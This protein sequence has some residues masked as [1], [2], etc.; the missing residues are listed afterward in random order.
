MNFDFQTNDSSSAEDKNAKTENG[1]DEK[2]PAAAID[3]G[4]LA[5][6]LCPYRASKEVRKLND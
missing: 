2:T 4:R 1:K 6:D 3:D 5:C